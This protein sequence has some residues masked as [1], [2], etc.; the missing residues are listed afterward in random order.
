MS[1]IMHLIIIHYFRPCFYKRI[2]WERKKR[3]NVKYHP[4]YYEGH[5]QKNSYSDMKFESNLHLLYG[6]KQ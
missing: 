3:E 4:E 2:V 1:L 5:K 6:I